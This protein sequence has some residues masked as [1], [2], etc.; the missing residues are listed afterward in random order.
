[1][2][3]KLNWAITAIKEQGQQVDYN[4]LQYPSPHF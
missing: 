4:L 3:R 2:M 1:M